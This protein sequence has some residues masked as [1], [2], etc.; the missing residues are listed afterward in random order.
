MDQARHYVCESCM[1]PVPSGHKFCG[2]CGT[3][4]PEHILHLSANFY[5][6]MQ[7][8]GK[9]RLILIRG[10]GMD[11]LSYHL[12]PDQHIVGRSGQLECPE[13]PF[14]SPKHANFY[15]RDSKQKASRP[16]LVWTEQ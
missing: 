11:G 9:A 2:R 7:D 14:I 15:Y 5:S 8:P 12:K 13:D 1:T 6:D 3:P 4:V 10:E 16:N